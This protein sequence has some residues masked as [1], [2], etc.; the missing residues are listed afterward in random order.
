M[1]NSTNKTLF[2]GACPS[3]FERICNNLSLT[4]VFTRSKLI[5]LSF[6]SLLYSQKFRNLFSVNYNL[7]LNFLKDLVAIDTLIKF[8]S[9]RYTWYFTSSYWLIL[10]PLCVKFRKYLFSIEQNTFSYLCFLSQTSMI[11]RTAKERG[12]CFFNSF[13]PFPS[14]SQVLTY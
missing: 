1:K 9:K 4:L 3:V 7:M 8:E 2:M 6:L 12:G 14:T 5:P 11:H 10:W 13:L